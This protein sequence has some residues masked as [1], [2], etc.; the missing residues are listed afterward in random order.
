MLG[1]RLADAIYSFGR[2]RPR[3]QAT[4]NFWVLLFSLALSI[5]TSLLFG[6]APALAISRIDLAKSL[7]EGSRG[8]TARRRVLRQSLVTFEIAASLILLMGAGLLARSFANLADE[9][10]GFRRENV[11]AATVALP[12]AKY[13]QP[14]RLAFTR[15][16]LGRA[17]AIPGVLSDGVVDVLPYRGGHGSAIQ[18][19]GNPDPPGEVV[20]QT[21]TSP[22]FFRTMGIP[23][24]R[25]RDFL[26]KEEASGAAVIDENVARKVFPGVDPIGR[27]VTLPRAG[28]T[29]PVVGIVGAIKSDPPTEPPPPRIYYLGPQWFLPPVCV[30]VKTQQNPM[31]LAGAIRHEV[32]ALDPE[33]P[34]YVNSMEEIMVQSLSRQRFAVW[35]M[36]AFA[37]LAALLAVVGIYG[38]LAYL[39]NQRRNEFGIRMAL[40]ARALDVLALVIRGTP[41]ATRCD[42]WLWRRECRLAP[43]GRLSLR[44][45][46]E[47]ADETEFGRSGVP[48]GLAKIKS[49]SA[50]YS[51]PNCARNSSWRFRCASRAASA[52]AG[53][54]RSRG[55]S[56]FVPL[57]FSACLV[58]L[59]DRV[60]MARPS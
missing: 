31:T 4:V 56:D 32:A 57:N 52:D 13:G 10:P 54:F 51:G 12:P 2:F 27:Q 36:S 33:L 20:W 11:L 8:S 34:V 29:F 17:R 48:S 1:Q 3:A 41:S 49:K 47:T 38:V 46:S 53:T 58:W 43:L 30:V 15:A 24:L 21:H 26:S 28:A 55:L 18:I 35:L 50:R 23:I 9:D 6:L 7:K 22:D 39:T 44:N 42:P 5:A 16:L 59:S 60:M 25:G 14:Q 45:S 19:P 40:G 37:M